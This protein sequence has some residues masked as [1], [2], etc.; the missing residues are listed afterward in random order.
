MVPFLACE[1]EVWLD[2]LRSHLFAFLAT[3]LL[4]FAACQAAVFMALW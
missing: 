3:K 4:G 1:V 2:L